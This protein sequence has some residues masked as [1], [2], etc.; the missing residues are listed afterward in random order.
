MALMLEQY[1][2]WQWLLLQ[3][4]WHQH[5][6][7]VVT[8]E[9]CKWCS[10]DVVMKGLLVPRVEYSLVSQNVVMLQLL[11]VQSRYEAQCEFPHWSN[12]FL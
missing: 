7:V 4:S 12:A 8:G 5:A 11:M 10:R 6:M 3:A 1:G 2:L 9:K